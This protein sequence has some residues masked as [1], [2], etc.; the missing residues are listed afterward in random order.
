MPADLPCQKVVQVLL[1][2]GQR[3]RLLRVRRQLHSTNVP[4]RLCPPAH[5][6]GSAFCETGQR[7]RKQNPFDEP[8]D[9]NEVGRSSSEFFTQEQAW[10]RDRDDHRRVGVH[11]NR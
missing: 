10:A 5:R 11:L 8:A 2:L 3:H 6:M 9:I 7:G 4:P 1:R